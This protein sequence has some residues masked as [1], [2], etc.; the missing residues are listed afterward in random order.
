MFENFNSNL[1]Y[2][3][4]EIKLIN[5]LYLVSN[6]PLD[7]IHLVYLGVMYKLIHFWLSEPINKNVRLPTIVQHC[8]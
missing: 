5:I 6:V 4:E 7:Y 1:N 2:Q 8:E 3:N